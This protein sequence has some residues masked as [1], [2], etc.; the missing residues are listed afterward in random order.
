MI[1]ICPDHTHFPDIL[2]LSG[3]ENSSLGNHLLNFFFCCHLAHRHNYRLIL[4][5]IGNLERVLTHNLE[6]GNPP[7]QSF[8]EESVLLNSKAAYKDSLTLLRTGIRYDASI[9][10]LF[11]HYPLI[12]LDAIYRYASFKKPKWEPADNDV[13]IHIRGRDFLDHGQGYF[14][15][16]VPKKPYYDRAIH[17]ARQNIETPSFKLLTDDEQLSKSILDGQDYELIDC[18]SDEA[19]LI[20]RSSKNLITSCSCF[21]WTAAL[22]SKDFLA[23]PLAGYNF[24]T[25]ERGEFRYGF[26]IAG[27]HQID[28]RSHIQ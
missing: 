9:K 7:E 26:A 1:T 20:M 5:K 22:F 25:P 15:S 11:W 14:K 24:E 17:A 3:H 21:S 23:Q 16:I 10:G 8:N 19:W 28:G 4:P 2:F 18:D 13:I 6:Y 27:A 12:N